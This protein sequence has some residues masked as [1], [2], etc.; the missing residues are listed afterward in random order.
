MQNWELDSCFFFFFFLDSCFLRFFPV[1]TLMFNFISAPLFLEKLYCILRTDLLLREYK[2]NRALFVPPKFSPSIVITGSQRC[3]RGE[4]TEPITSLGESR[5][6]SE[7]VLIRS[8]LKEER[9]PFSWK[10][11]VEGVGVQSI[12]WQNG[13]A[14]QLFSRDQNRLCWRPTSETF[15]CV[16]NLKWWPCCYCSLSQENLAYIRKVCGS[17]RGFEM[18]P[19]V[20]PIYFGILTCQGHGGGGHPSRGWHIWVPN[21]I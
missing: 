14:K 10:E 15:C 7:L 13:W 2:T 1:P 19:Q 21:I 20:E 6:I 12:S 8:F 3:R 9:F 4:R 18:H 5:E 17:Q 11:A 16:L